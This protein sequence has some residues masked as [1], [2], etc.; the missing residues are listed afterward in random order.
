MFG[1]AEAW[2]RVGGKIIKYESFESAAAAALNESVEAEAVSYRVVQ[3]EKPEREGSPLMRCKLI[4]A[5]LFSAVTAAHAQQNDSK[6]VHDMAIWYCVAA[7]NA[8]ANALRDDRQAYHKIIEA[9]GV[10]VAA[11]CLP[12]MKASIGAGDDGKAEAD[13]AVDCAKQVRPMH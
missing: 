8:E 1:P 2:V 11:K 5:I 13:A 3:I 4:V 6:T 10:A 7:T 9:C 12:Q